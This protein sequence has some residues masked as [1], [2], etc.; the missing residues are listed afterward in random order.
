[1]LS[2]PLDI[3]D[4]VRR[5]VLGELCQR[6]GSTCPALI[7]EDDAIGMRVKE[8]A[9]HGVAATA[10]PAMHKQH[11]HALRIATLLEIQLVQRRYPKITGLIGFDGRIEDVIDAV[12]SHAPKMFI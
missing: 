6:L 2:K 7:E 3:G 5:G 11:W 10:G 9:L 1:M 12:H 4:Q 8:A